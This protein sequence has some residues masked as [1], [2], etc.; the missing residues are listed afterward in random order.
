VDIKYEVNEKIIG[1][2]QVIVDDKFLDLSVAS[3]IAELSKILE[4]S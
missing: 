4:S 2:L 1:G 3:R